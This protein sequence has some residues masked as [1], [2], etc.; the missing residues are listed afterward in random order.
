[1]PGPPPD[2]AGP[3][4]PSGGASEDGPRRSGRQRTHAEREGNV[5]PPGKTAD[6]DLRRKLGW[7][8]LPT[9]SVP[10]QPPK[11]SSDTQSTSL[12]E[13]VDSTTDGGVHWIESLLA[14]ALPVHDSIPNPDNVRDWTNKDIDRLPADQQKEWR[15]A[16]FEELEALK[17]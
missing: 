4:A 1:M 13:I 14:K 8:K 6:K 15:Q 9:G 10:E 17:R 12:H 11:N 3:S 2:Q 7:V 5:Y 16:Q